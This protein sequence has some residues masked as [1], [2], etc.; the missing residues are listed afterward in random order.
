MEHKELSK[1]QGTIGYLIAQN[2]DKIDAARTKEELIGICEQML[3]DSDNKGK[4]AFLF[5]LGRKKTFEDALQFV[6]DYLLRGDGYGVI[7]RRV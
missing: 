4:T 5:Y 6:Y 2:R 7:T 3:W 1:Q